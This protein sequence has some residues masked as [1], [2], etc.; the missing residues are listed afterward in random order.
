MEENKI[1]CSHCGVLIEDEDFD[2]VNGEPICQDCADRY[3]V[4]CDR[5]RATIW[6]STLTAMITQIFVHTVTKITTHAAKNVIRL[7]TETTL[8]A[9]R[10][11]TTAPNAIM[12]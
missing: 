4:I 7:F 12:K 9:L 5:C 3:T 8:F 10:T 2:T 11:A 1:R 6:E